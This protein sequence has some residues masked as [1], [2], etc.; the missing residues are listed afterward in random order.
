MYGR[1]NPPEI[2]P[3]TAVG[4]SLVIQ[5]V[6]LTLKTVEVITR[7]DFLTPRSSNSVDDYFF[8]KKGEK[9]AKAADKSIT[10]HN[11]ALADNLRMDPL[12]KKDVTTYHDGR[13]ATVMTWKYNGERVITQYDENGQVTVS[14]DL[15]VND[16]VNFKDGF[17]S[18]IIKYTGSFGGKLDLTERIETQYGE[19]G[20]ILSSTN[21]TKHKT[22]II[23]KTGKWLTTQHTTYHTNGRPNTVVAY[24]Q[25]TQRSAIDVHDK[26][27]AYAQMN[28]FIFGGGE[29]IAESYMSQMTQY[30]ESGKTIISLQLNEFDEVNFHP[31]G[32]VAT[33]LKKDKDNN[34][35]SL[36]SY[37]EN[38]KISNIMV[39]KDG[40][41]ISSTDY[42]D[43][44]PVSNTQQGNNEYQNI[45]D[46]AKKRVKKKTDK[47]KDNVIVQPENILE[48]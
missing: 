40:V 13:V 10:N 34:P 18:S 46:S 30:D 45:F 23:N 37:D 32:R 31:S 47:N 3:P 5:Q 9:M 36:T 7:Y 6:L 25:R 4:V 11:D 41:V 2:N 15:G 22:G 29:D 48:R 17:I 33:V 20:R 44:K 35:K 21:Q 8:I 24:K 39:Y 27:S 12:N 26:W 28:Q 14:Q 1:R 16:I 43:G 42:V 38:G 19:N